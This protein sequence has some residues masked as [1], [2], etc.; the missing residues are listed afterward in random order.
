MQRVIL[1]FCVLVALSVAKDVN[2]V[3]T[4]TDKKNHKSYEYD[5]SA[6]HHDDTTYVDTLWYRTDENVIYYV[7]FCGQTASACE[8]DDTS[9]C[10]RVPDGED[11][12]YFGGGKTSS[13]KITSQE[14]KEQ[15]PSTSVT[16]T[17]SN[18]DSC[19]SDPSTNYKTKIYVNCQETANPGYFWKME[20]KDNCDVTLYMW[21]ASG[22]GK[23]VPYVEPSD[24]ESGISGGEIFSIVSLVVLSVGLIVYFAVG[25][26]YNFKFKDA[27]A[28]PDLII[29]RDFW[30]SL[31]FLV[32]DGVLFIGHGF[33]KGD[34]V[35]V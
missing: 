15:S 13:Q 16:V 17:Y 4:I 11:Y 2:C 27:R 10:I 20:T 33:K 25:A 28:L 19:Q 32:K 24:D 7:N 34:Y 26:F 22:C 35:S 12:Q 3:S 14:A 30:C 1:A 23:E 29:H 9:V 6:L 8:S 5:L 31:P 21:A 18:G